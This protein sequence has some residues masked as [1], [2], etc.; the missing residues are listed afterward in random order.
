MIAVNSPSF[1]AILSLPLSSTAAVLAAFA[2]N[3]WLPLIIKNMLAGTALANSSSGSSGSSSLNHSHSTT[4]Q[5][6]LLAAIPYVCATAANLAVAWHADR[7]NERALH[8]GVPFV[9]GGV[10]LAA[11][12]A[13][14]KLSFTAGFAGLVVAMAC[15][16]GG[17]S[18]LLASVAGGRLRELVSGLMF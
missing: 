17:Q 9:L 7:V 12:S 11:F 8:T 4:R 6:T 1:A 13:L 2:L 10:M 15:A 16:Y 18:T 5:A 3:S 14:T